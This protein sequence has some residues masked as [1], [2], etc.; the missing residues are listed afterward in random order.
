M[1]VLV[2]LPFWSSYLLR[3][4]A[5]MSILGERGLINRGLMSLG[6]L[7][8]AGPL[9]TLQRFRRHHRRGLSLYPL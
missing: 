6:I 3:V 2:I 5:W 9:P 1:L 7:D 8:D 4:Y